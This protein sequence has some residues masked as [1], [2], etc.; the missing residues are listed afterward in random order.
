MLCTLFDFD[1]GT[2]AS[3]ATGFGSYVHKFFFHFSLSLYI[4]I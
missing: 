3:V 1:V 2:R 4:Y